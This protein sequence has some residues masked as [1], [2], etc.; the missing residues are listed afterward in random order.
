MLYSINVL[1]HS[2]SILYCLTIDKEFSW[3]SVHIA[4]IFSW[5]IVHVNYIYTQVICMTKGLSMIARLHFQLCI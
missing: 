5:F 1:F 4:V 3:C 2:Q